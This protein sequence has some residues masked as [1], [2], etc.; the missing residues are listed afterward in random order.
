[1]RTSTS[2]IYQRGLSNNFIFQNRPISVFAPHVESFDFSSTRQLCRERCVFV[3]DAGAVRMCA[4][5]YLWNHAASV[6][7]F[8]KVTVLLLETR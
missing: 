8:R 6:E 5:S 7:V 3:S 2:G 1:M 4:L